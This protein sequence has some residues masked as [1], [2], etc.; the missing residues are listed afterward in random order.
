MYKDAI[1]MAES[2]PH[3]LPPAAPGPRKLSKLYS[4]SSESFIIV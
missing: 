2:A 1:D 3:P 4:V